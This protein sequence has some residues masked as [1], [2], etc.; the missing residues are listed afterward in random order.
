MN[1]NQL[2]KIAKKANEKNINFNINNPEDDLYFYHKVNIG[3]NL[4]KKSD[5]VKATKYENEHFI[6]EF[7]N[8]YYYILDELENKPIKI[9]CYCILKKCFSN[10]EEDDKKKV[11]VDYMNPYFLG[12]TN[13]TKEN[14][15]NNKN[16]YSLYD[17]DENE[18]SEKT[19]LLILTFEDYSKE[20]PMN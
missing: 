5:L 1:K 3:N 8:E 4:K 11:L 15:D 19:K 12:E 13:I 6:V 16:E 7:N 10:N 20:K 18:L 14:I 2:N 17:K 9:E